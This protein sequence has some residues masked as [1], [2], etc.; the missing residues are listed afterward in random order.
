M[1]HYALTA[2]LTAIGAVTILRAVYTLYG[3]I[4]LHFTTPKRPLH[5]YK[6]AGKQP[7]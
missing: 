5:S 4:R 1:V 2:G 6:R 3:F 7:T